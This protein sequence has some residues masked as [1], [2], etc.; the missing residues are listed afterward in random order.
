M[1]ALLLSDQSIVQI[2]LQQALARPGRQ[3]ELYRTARLQTALEFLVSGRQVVAVIIDLAWCGM[4]TLEP[5]VQRL[6]GAAGQIPLMILVDRP[7]EIS[8]IRL[9]GLSADLYLAKTASPAAMSQ[10][11]S[12]LVWI[13]TSVM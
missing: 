7:D 3:V 4:R 2:G 11:L 6:M 8:Q 1:K 13:G 12:K 9:K 5:V 10:A